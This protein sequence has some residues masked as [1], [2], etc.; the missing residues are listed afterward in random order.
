VFKSNVKEIRTQASD[1]RTLAVA[2]AEA[3]LLHAVVVVPAPV[4]VHLHAALLAHF[5]GVEG[6]VGLPGR[7]VEE[8]QRRGVGPAPAN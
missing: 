1:V 4:R 3:S 6:G 2:A 7:P 5:P 8:A